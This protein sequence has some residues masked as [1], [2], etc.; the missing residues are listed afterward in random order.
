MAKIISIHSFR[1][2]T[3]KSNLTANVATT[4]AL[5]GKRI[6]IIDTDIQSPGIHVLFGL[7]G[8]T[9]DHSLNDY[10][11]GKCSIHQT[12]HPVLDG[13]VSGQVF[14]VPSSIKAD[15]IVQVLRQGY[16]MHLLT[17]AFLTLAF[18]AVTCSCITAGDRLAIAAGT[19]RLP[20]APVPSTR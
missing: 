16:D 12:A 4:L 2:G 18:M 19:S 7:H 15:A 14:L 9:I 20:L 8:D 13:A 17:A 1:G 6:G 5:G 11:W 10:L 3:G